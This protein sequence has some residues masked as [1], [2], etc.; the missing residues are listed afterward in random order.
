MSTLVVTGTDTGVGKTVASVLLMRDAIQKGS[1]VAGF[2]P[3]ASGAVGQES[4]LRNDDALALQAAASRLWPYKTVNPYC[5]A[6]PIAPHIAAE[7]IGT[8]VRISSLD[9]AHAQLAAESDLVVIEGAG[10]WLVPLNADI[11]FAGWVAQ[12]GWPVVLVVGMRLGCI[13]HAL[14][15]VEAITRR[16]RLA[17]WIANG[18]E[19]PMTAF[20]ETLTSLR[21]RIAAPLWGVIPSGAPET[22][23][24]DAR[25]LDQLAVMGVDDSDAE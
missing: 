4:D 7:S 10:G 2:K 24:F 3:I 21:R 19:A 22:T 9:A 25:W 15:S 12:R 1:R 23:C 5:F 11:S 6:P 14:L 16:T 13:N 17:G 18:L 8:V 20:D